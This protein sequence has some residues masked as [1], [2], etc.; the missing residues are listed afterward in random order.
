MT[1]KELI[2]KIAESTGMSKKVIETVL[3]AQHEEIGNALHEGRD[4]D[5]NTVFIPGF[6]TFTTS[7]AQARIGKNPRTKE[8]MEIPASY[9]VGFR[10][11]KALKDKINEK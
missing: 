10:A 9:R 1:K 7:F 8:E 6:G 11:A 2:T 3:K 4:E 5:T